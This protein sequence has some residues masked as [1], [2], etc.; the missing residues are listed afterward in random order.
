VG[1]CPGGSCPSG[2]LSGGQLSWTRAEETEI[3]AT[4]QHLWPFCAFFLCTCTESALFMLP[5]WNLLSL[6]F[7]EIDF[8]QRDRN[9]CDL[10]TFRI[11]CSHILLCM[12]RNNYF[13]ASGWNHDQGHSFSVANFAKF[14]GIICQ[15]PWNCA[16]LLCP[17]TLHSTASWHCCIKWQHFKV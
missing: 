3:S 11:I 10:T 6:S 15:I 8:L 1:S 16:A 13:S 4:G 14:R 7:W 5:L 12:H 2:Q 17:N 9:I